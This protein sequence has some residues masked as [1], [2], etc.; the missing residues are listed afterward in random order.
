MKRL[1]VTLVLAAGISFL[2]A[3][4]S[5]NAPY[6]EAMQ[7]AMR[8]MEER[9][10]SARIY[11]SSLDSVIGNEPEETRMYYRLL[12]TKAEDKEHIRHTSDSLIK[13]VVHFYESDGDIEKLMEAY[14][15]LGSVYRDM[16]DAPRAMVAFQKAI[17]VGGNTPRYDIVGRVYEQ[18]GTLL[19]YQ[20]LYEDALKVY[21]TSYT[22]YI[23]QDDERGLVYA[24]RNQGRMYEVLNRLDSAEY[25]YQAAHKKASMLNYQQLINSISIEFG[26]VYLRIGKPAHAMKLFSEIPQNHKEE[27]AIY[28][29]GL[30]S[31]YMAIAKPDSAQHYYKEALK[32]GKLNQNI[33]MRSSIYK[34]LSTIEA[35]QGHYPLAFE[36]AE[37]SLACEDSIKEMT[38][39]EAIGKI[40]A[41]Y[42]YRHTEEENQQLLL[43]SQ[44]TQIFIYLLIIAVLL[45]ACIAAIYF[46]QKRLAQEQINRLFQQ[47]EE[48]EKYSQ[49]RLIKNRKK[50]LEIK[51]Q[52]QQTKAEYEEKNSYLTQA[53]K[54]LQQIPQLKARLTEAEE[55]AHLTMAEEKLLKAQL[56]KAEEKLLKVQQERLELDNQLIKLKEYEKLIQKD[57]FENTSIYRLFHETAIENGSKKIKKEDWITLIQGIDKAYNNF[58]DRLKALYPS[59]T[60]HELHMCYLIKINIVPS[61]MAKILCKST[62]AISNGRTRLYQKISKQEGNGEMLDKLIIDL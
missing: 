3:C 5:T 48:Q 60:Q 22:Y 45:I 24:L 16:K 35:Q 58:T 30:G 13:E 8:C 26:N 47:K 41:L 12:T 40:H 61:G 10:D 55:N 54:K 44:Q 4:T 51:K 29:Y 34:A 42:N 62:S 59:I 57:I 20:S 39:T 37:K 46:Y 9:S 38:R 11:L 6:P 32:K 18:M 1:K 53:Q 7:K 56:T 27:D 23:K 14:Y 43:K 2:F 21:K 52:L 50:I 19:A 36:Y 31:A 28:L 49:D 17:K 33:Y 15:Y 25:Y